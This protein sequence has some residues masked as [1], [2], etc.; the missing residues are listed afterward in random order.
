MDFKRAPRF[1]RRDSLWPYIF[2]RNIDDAEIFL[3]KIAAQPKIFEQNSG[4]AKN[5]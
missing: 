4:A 2:S 5:F 1:A 3:R